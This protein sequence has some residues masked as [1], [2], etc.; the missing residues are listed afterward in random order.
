M[1][2]V[3]RSPVGALLARPWVDSVG[4]FG[5]R[6][7]YLPMSRL[8]AAANAAGDDVAQFRGGIGTALSGVWSDASLAR[9]LRRHRVA[10]EGAAGARAAWEAAAFAAQPGDP[11]VLDHQR[12]VAATRH[13]STRGRFYPLLFGADIP[14]AR[15]QIVPPGEIERDF[16]GTAPNPAQLY[17]AP[18]APVGFTV[19]PSFTRAGVRQYWLKAPTPASRLARRAG[20]EMTYARMIEPVGTTACETLIFGSGL[21]LELELLNLSEDPGARL[22]R[23]GWRVVEPISPYHGLRAMPGFYGGEP[24]FAA[25]PTSAVDL[26]AGQTIETAALVGWCRSRFDGPVAVAGISMTSFV[27]QQVASHCGTWPA[28][29]RPDAVMLISHSGRMQATAFGGE[30]SAALGLERA[31]RDAGWTPDGLARLSRALDPAEAPALAPSRIVSVLGETDRWVPYEDGLDLARRWK[32]PEQNVFRYPLGHL[33][34]PV[35]LVRDAAP[36]ER[37]RQVLRDA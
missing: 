22:A 17:A 9:L 27:A 33:G 16:G 25:G 34:M 13:L 35:Q 7:W 28:A 18:A 11:A 14:A 2:V 5:L 15:W 30:L 24:F 12:R 23:A 36:F 1:N 29:M 19:S 10:Q 4:L 8:W 21:C 6:R 26:V 31:L 37:L 32:L 20:S 3:F